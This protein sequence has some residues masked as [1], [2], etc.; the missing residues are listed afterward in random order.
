MIELPATG[1]DLLRQARVMY[2]STAHWLP[3]ANGYSPYAPPTYVAFM[4]AAVRLPD[5]TALDEMLAVAPLRWVVVNRNGVDP[6]AWP[7]WQATFA[8]A[9]LRVAAEFPQSTVFEVPP[10][11]RHAPPASPPGGAN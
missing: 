3:L 4:Q 8:N 9:G 10:E 6:H 5:A 1:N 11:R 7:A 2:F